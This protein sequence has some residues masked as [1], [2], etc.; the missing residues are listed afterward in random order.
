MDSWPEGQWFDDS[1]VTINGKSDDD[2]E[3]IGDTD[4]VEFTAGVVFADAHDKEGKS[5]T[6]HFSA[7]L[8][9]QNTVAVICE[10]PKDQ[11]D[12]LAAAIKA[13]GGRVRK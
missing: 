8:K 3:V 9:A 13:L 4:A 6:R 2:V 11:L 5:L 12:A 7:W 1:D 10:V